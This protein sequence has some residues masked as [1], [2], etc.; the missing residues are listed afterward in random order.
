MTNVDKTPHSVFDLN[1]EIIVNVDYEVHQELETLQLCL[2]ASRNMME[3]FSS[4][5]TD[6]FEMPLIRRDPGKYH[7]EFRLEPRVLKAGGYSILVNFGTISTLLL[8]VPDAVQFSIEELSENTTYRSYKKERLGHIIAPGTW[9]TQV[10]LA[11]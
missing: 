7:A 8:E 5:D 9:H 3:L 4:Y 6:E 11:E 10:K 1:D 2:I